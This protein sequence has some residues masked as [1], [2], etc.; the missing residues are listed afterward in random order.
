VDGIWGAQVPLDDA[1]LARYGSWLVSRASYL[2]NGDLIVFVDEHPNPA[3]EP[4]TC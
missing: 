2:G 4:S 1:A 3:P